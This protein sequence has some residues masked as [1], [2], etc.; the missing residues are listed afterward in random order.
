M[1]SDKRFRFPVV[2]LVMTA[3]GLA[4]ALAP[5]LSSVRSAPA[6][7][8]VAMSRFSL[9]LIVLGLLV[10][11]A[12]RRVRRRDGRGPAVAT[13]AAA[14][15]VVTSFVTAPGARATGG[16]PNPLPEDLT[17]VSWK[18]DQDTVPPS[19]IERLAED[20]DADV[21]VLPEYFGPLASAQLGPWATENG[22]QILWYDSSASSVL[23]SERLGTY[24]VDGDDAPPWAGFVAV[25]DADENP[26]LVIAHLEHARLWSAGLWNEHLTW[27]ASE[28]AQE[29]VVAVGDFNATRQNLQDGTL[30][31][32]AD[33]A[34]ATGETGTG[35]WPV[36]L[37]AF[38]GAQIDRVMT[39]ARWRTVSFSVVTSH[40]REGSDH[41][42][43]VAHVQKGAPS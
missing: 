20:H 15:L 4:L 3:V 26:R 12:L 35:T 7:H 38:L 27:V 29:N 39:G 16:P 22:F 30:G 6:M 31:A 41:R 18:T 40:D 11:A 5:R 25:P 17:I 24:T 19:S 37:P 1:I 21:I 2:V 33:G 42:P 8:V 34:T 13:V 9:A 23:I 43:I 10:L 28:C 36:V 32:C 14:A